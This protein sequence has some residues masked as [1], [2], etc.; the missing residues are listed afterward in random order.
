M[1][2]ILTDK[3]A[4]DALAIRSTL[5][6]VKRK[7]GEK[8]REEKSRPPARKTQLNQ[9]ERAR[10]REIMFRAFGAGSSPATRCRSIS[11]S[12]KHDEK[13]FKTLISGEE[14]QREELLTTRLR[15]AFCTRE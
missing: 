11:R 12:L 8:E 15:H 3:L 13:K 9:E 1:S 7:K 4:A 5:E 6:Q 14:T 10:V 2:R